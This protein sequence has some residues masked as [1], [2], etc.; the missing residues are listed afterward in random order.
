MKKPATVI[1]PLALVA[2]LLTAGLAAQHQFFL[3]GPD[4]GFLGVQIRDVTAED[5]RNLNLPRE[6]G[7]YLEKVQPDTPASQA[8]LRQ[9][10]VITEFAGVPVLSARQFQRV[11]AETPGGREV[12]LTLSRNGQTLTKSVTVG[13][14]RLPGRQLSPEEGRSWTPQMPEF[15]FQFPEG[16]GDRMGDV[17]VFS[18][19]RGRL[20]INGSNLTDQMAQFLNVPG[21]TGVLVMSVREDTPAHRAGLKAGDVIVAVN[22]SRVDG[23]SQL[24]RQLARDGSHELDVVRDGQ[25]QKVTVQLGRERERRGRGSS[26]L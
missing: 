15:S 9:G 13:E 19:E 21:E 2:F 8:D 17:F 18:G 12:A 3:H 25:V 10:D 24:S 1:T 20:G 6:A 14:G 7:V 26:R 22:G 5:V 11:I 4:R 16:L 23:L